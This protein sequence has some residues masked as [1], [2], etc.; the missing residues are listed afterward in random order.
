MDGHAKGGGAISAVAA[1]GSPVIFIGTGEHIHD[2]EPFNPTTFVNKMLGMGDLS[3]LLEKLQDSNIDKE[4]L[5]RNITKGIF[6]FR[7]MK[8]QFEMI[9]GT[10]ELS[11]LIDYLGMGPMSKIMGMIPGMP[12]GLSNDLMDNQG[13]QKLKHYT[14][15]MDSMTEKELDSSAALF[16]DQPSR[17]YR[18]AR[19]AGVTIQEVEELL[20][21]HDAVCLEL[22]LNFN[23]LVILDVWYGEILGWTK[24]T[25]VGN[26]K[27]WNAWDGNASSRWNA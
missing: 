13:S 2:L 4:G 25:V 24:W 9:S 8:G 27:A 17:I 22:I 15:L 3:G 21:Q 16:R 19:G 7:D 26:A 10:W 5:I 11:C 6:T 20:A 12:Q 14:C 18:V 23:F 1:T